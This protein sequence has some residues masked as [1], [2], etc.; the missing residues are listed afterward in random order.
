[1]AKAQVIDRHWTPLGHVTAAMRGT[2]KTAIDREMATLLLEDLPSEEVLEIASAIRD[3]L[4]TTAFKRQTLEVERQRVEEERRHKNEVEALGAF[5]RADR[6]KKLFIQQANHQAQAYCEE[7]EITGL[8]Q[9]R[10]AGDIESRL[11][12]FLTGDESITEGQ[13]IVRSVLDARFAE[14]DAKLTAAQAK[15]NEKWQEEITGLLVL[16]ALVGL[17]VLA[18]KYPSQ[19]LSILNWI[20]RTFG[21]T[22]GTEAGPPTRDASETTPPA[23][24][25][26]SRPPSRRR[27]KDPVS[28]SSLESS[29]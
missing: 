20:E 11:D 5:I 10:V 28:P 14:A 2:A 9:L 21:L 26:E 16:G 22:P 15:A 24:S 12:E 27:R 13:A 4:Y 6:R 23:A 19:A 17:V 1:V 7:K 18:V 25:A 8:A 3:R 29:R